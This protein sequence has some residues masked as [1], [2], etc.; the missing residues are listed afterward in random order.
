MYPLTKDPEEIIALVNKCSP[1]E[2]EE[3][4]PEILGNHPN[5]YT[6][7][8]HMAEHEVKKIEQDVPTA[9]VRPSMSKLK[10]LF[11]VVKQY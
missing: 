11:S 2:I 8:K 6:I 7:T 5:P 4:L 9:I 10:Y 1:E 3:Q